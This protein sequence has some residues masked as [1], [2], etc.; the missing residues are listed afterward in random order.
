MSARKASIVVGTILR[1]Q[2]GGGGRQCLSFQY[3]HNKSGLVFTTN[4]INNKA[5]S[6]LSTGL[7][8][9]AVHLRETI[10]RAPRAVGMSKCQIE[11]IK[12]G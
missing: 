7:P 5:R 3:F 11:I 2:Q 6:C 8:I 9:P 12:D 10:L 4:G 1:A